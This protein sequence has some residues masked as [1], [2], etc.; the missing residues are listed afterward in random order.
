VLTCRDAGHDL[1][2]P[3]CSVQSATSL[4]ASFPAIAA[5]LD[6]CDL[7]NAIDAACSVLLR[8]VSNVLSL[9]QLQR[10]GALA[11]AP[12]LPFELRACIARAVELVCA[13]DGEPPRIS[14]PESATAALPASV[15]ADQAALEAC[16]QN[17]LLAAVRL[18]AWQ[19]THAAVQ[20]R[21]AAEPVHIDTV[22][23]QV[24]ACEASEAEKEAHPDAFE[25]VVDAETPGRPLTP[26]E[27]EVMLSPFGMIPAAKGGGTGLALFVARGLARGMGGELSIGGC[28]AEDCTAEHGEST[29]IHLRIPLQVTERSMLPEAP[30]DAVPAQPSEDGDAAENENSSGAPEEAPPPPLDELQL[31][32]RMFETLLT[33]SD[34]VFARCRISA[35]DATAALA[36]H[37]PRIAV[38]VEYISPSVERGLAFCQ[39]SVVGTQLTD[40]CHPEDRAGFL[41]AI[42][43]AFRGDGPDG[44][45]LLFMHRSMTASGGSIWCHTAGLCEGDLLFLVCRDVRARKSVELALR[46][47]T[48]AT[49]HDV[50][51]SCN[52]IL[53][54]VAVLERRACIS[55]LDTAAP[56]SPP[57]SGPAAPALNANFLVSCIRAACGLILGII[58]NVL[59]APEVQAGKMTL[60]REVFNPDSVLT[61][62]L[63]ACRF[64]CAAAAAP[65][66]GIEWQAE[67]LPALV[68]GDRCRLAQVAQNL[69]SAPYRFA[70]APWLI[71]PQAATQST[72]TQ[73]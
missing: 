45:H 4:L 23:L 15:R 43:A 24:V 52:A 66:G 2:T 32:A 21:V 64:G 68:E 59:T 44:H 54:S 50:R 35:L 13:F 46:A 48:L 63:Q 16:L 22:C 30:C 36:P 51:E 5:D 12:P 53:V 29:L 70:K 27:C 62:V 73:C 33:N 14:W 40:V 6:A 42:D 19:P 49:T 56:A 67:P 38:R 60:Q 47:F 10:D 20:L 25:L 34:D 41:A 65:G 1:R 55:A 37:A 58:G 71:Q 72:N 17:V 61:D 39:Q 9:R 26:H 57:R 7:L 31:T 28:A 18:G 8:V 3:C 11:L 69:V